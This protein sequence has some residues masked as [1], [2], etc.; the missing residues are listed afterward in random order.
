MVGTDAPPVDLAAT[1]LRAVGQQVVVPGSHRFAK[2]RALRAADLS[3]EPIV[4][5]P[6]G[7]PH[8]MMLQQ[9][10]RASG[11]DLNVA[12][13][14]TGWELMLQFARCGI[15]LAVVNDFCPVP[16]GM[17][18]VP[19][20]GAPKVIY[21]LIVRKGLTNKGIEAMAELIAQTMRE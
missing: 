4:V 1:P 2:R 12:V 16:K 10:M 3:G 17:V 21:Y 18:G 20:E 5:A 6:A 9:L 7:S 19:L 13:E 11:G 15:A 8:R 14:A